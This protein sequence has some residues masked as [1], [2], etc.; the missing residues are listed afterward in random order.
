MYRPECATH[1][2][3]KILH[4]HFWFISNFIT[5]RIVIITFFLLRFVF[6]WGLLLFSLE[7]MLQ[8]TMQ[9]VANR[10]ALLHCTPSYSSYEICGAGHTS[11]KTNRTPADTKM[12]FFPQKA[13]QSQLKIN[14]VQP[15]KRDLGNLKLF[16]TAENLNRNKQAS[17]LHKATS[18][19]ICG[20]LE[21][22]F[23]L[24]RRHEI[25][26]SPFTKYSCTCTR[27]LK[28]SQ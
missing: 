9:K 10:S 18:L 17:H 5:Y 4:F 15:P 12:R 13:E 1:T 27:A 24:Y 23:Y 22:L 21:I 26:N 25:M 2:I 19:L 14:E 11:F 28:L 3:W 20:K 6:S 8:I 16:A 7:F